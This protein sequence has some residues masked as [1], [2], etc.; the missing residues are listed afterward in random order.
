MPKG[1]IR[2]LHVFGGL[3]LGGA[4]SRIVDLY[5]F[6]DRKKIRF[7]FLVHVDAQET[8]RGI[9]T[10]EELME[11]RIPEYF[12]AYVKKM[13][14]RIFAVPRFTGGNLL[15]YTTA[16]EN[17]FEAHKGEWKVVQGHM[18]STASLYLPIAKRHGVQVTIAHA[19][20]AGTDPGLKGAATKTLRLPLRL[21]KSV[22]YYFACSQEAGRAAF[23]KRMVD[24]KAVRII[25]NAID[26]D[27]FLYNE[28][29]RDRIREE[30]KVENAIVIGHVGRFHY[31]KNHEFLIRVFSW[32]RK[33]VRGDHLNEYALINGL[34]LKLMLL[35]EGELMYD[36]ERLA[37]QEALGNDVLFLSN[38]TNANEYYQAMDYF[39]FPSRYEGLPGTVVEAQAAGLQ[40]LI[41]DTITEEV[42]VTKLVS[43][44]SLSQP[45][46]VWASKVL[47]DLMLEDNNP[48]P[49]GRERV[50]EYS[51][52][53]RAASSPFV[54]RKIKNAGFD[55]RTQAR[56]MAYFYERGHF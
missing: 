14:A 53:D 51:I 11:I 44:M 43:R 28:D 32:M 49:G 37:E 47:H 45:E 3:G 9:P 6:I 34:K 40:C 8:G 50:Y 33:L 12:D 19:R 48:L 22:D 10:S 24:K 54:E 52:G 15:Q 7:D 20:S 36:I 56:Q 31:A 27:R 2:V 55:V 4:E 13:G 39:L 46:Q 25:P 26:V 21:E 1:P 23:G 5:R 42:A 17:F 41:S 30:L 16:L 18:T 29:A 35:G 38:K